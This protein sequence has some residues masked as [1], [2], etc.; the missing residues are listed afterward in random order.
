LSSTLIHK[1]FGGRV[2][3]IIFFLA[4]RLDISD[5]GSFYGATTSSLL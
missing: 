2:K 5:A 1:T 4:V 3:I